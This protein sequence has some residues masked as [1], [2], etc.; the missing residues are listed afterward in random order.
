MFDLRFRH[1]AVCLLACFGMVAVAAAD[2]GEWRKLE[3]EEAEL[4]RYIWQ[5]VQPPASYELDLADAK[6]YAYVLHQLELAGESPEKS[7]TLYRK[8]AEAH[9]EKKHRKPRLPRPDVAY[10]SA[11][12]GGLVPI[13]SLTYFQPDSSQDQKYKAAALSSY[14]GGTVMT[15][16]SIHMTAEESGTS[17]IF[18]KNAA[19]TQQYAQGE[20]FR[21]STS[22][23]VPS[24]ITSPSINAHVLILAQPTAKSPIQTTI[25]TGIDTDPSNTGCLNLPMYKKYQGQNK[26]INQ[27]SSTQLQNNL[28][29][30]WFRTPGNGKD[31]DYK[32]PDPHPAQYEFPIKG[33][34]SFGA[35]VN[36]V[37][38]MDLTLQRTSGGGGCKLCGSTAGSTERC[39]SGAGSVDMSQVTID[40]ST[41]AWDWSGTN[42]AKF[43]NGA[44][45]ITTGGDPTWFNLEMW[46]TL[47]N[48][49]FS[50]AQFT[51]PQTDQPAAPEYPMPVVRIWD[52]CL[53]ADAMIALGKG[54]R[55]TS[56]ASLRHKGGG[57]P[58]VLSDRPEGLKRALVATTSGREA[59][60]MVRIATKEYS[61]LLT[62]QHPVLREDGSV[63]AAEALEAGDVV[64]T[65]SGPQ[66]LTR[67]DRES[68]PGEVF[69]LKLSGTEAEVEAGQTTFY[70]N[71]FRV[72]DAAMQ[73]HLEDAKR[74]RRANRTPEEIRAELPEEWRIDFDNDRRGAKKP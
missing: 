69:N 25:D 37:N 16:I 20:N 41:I 70:A 66:P 1:I 23:T 6:Q 48:G 68:Y 5:Y 65:L 29:L 26:C 22:A 2:S 64:Q 8:L 63:A 47:D 3:P 14:A 56:I 31:C 13:N 67:V 35:G 72:G 40:G 44:N 34:A 15:H 42:I 61:L 58:S 57:S 21:L 39:R 17:A 46:V 43:P 4:H 28:N 60:P 54:K 27:L 45:C 50:Q 11:G 36:S 12:S 53:E 18:A 38:F 33:S 62:K 73:S 32:H 7:P 24:G 52:G 10:R 30:C 71:G 49:H 9:A 19:T 74:L 59:Q 55:Q 51:T